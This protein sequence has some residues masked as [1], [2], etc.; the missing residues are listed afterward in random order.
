LLLTARSGRWH[1]RLIGL[2][3]LLFGLNVLLNY[4]PSWHPPLELGLHHNWTGKLLSTAV[5]LL[6]V[7]GFRVASPA[8]WG[9]T[10]APQ[11]RAN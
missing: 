11:I 3:A 5:F 2:A 6:L 9:H 1:R 10:Y 8:E 7:Y 4:L